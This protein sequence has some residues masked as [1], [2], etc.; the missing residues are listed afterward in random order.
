M[1]IGYK[2][3]KYS[4]VDCVCDYH[5]MSNIPPQSTGSIL[6]PDSEDEES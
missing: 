4:M 6:A 2:L 3:L 1:A 5:N